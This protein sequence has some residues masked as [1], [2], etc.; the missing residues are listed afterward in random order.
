MEGCVVNLVSHCV[1][2]DINIILE[3]IFK[4]QEHQWVRFLCSVLMKV[5]GCMRDYPIRG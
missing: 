3:S 1:G 2:N 4:L 5:E